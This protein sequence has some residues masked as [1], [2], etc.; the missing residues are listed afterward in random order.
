MN[1]KNEALHFTYT[2]DIDPDELQE[3]IAERAYRKAEKR[4]FEPGHEM[5]DWLEAEQEVSNQC[6]YWSQG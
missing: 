4:G 1:T 3:M 5:A 6:R 2:S